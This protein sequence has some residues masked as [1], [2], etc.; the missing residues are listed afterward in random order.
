MLACAAAASDADTGPEMVPTLLFRSNSRNLKIIKKHL[1]KH[2]AAS[3]TIEGEA[4]KLP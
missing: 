3:A 2:H 1:N 4:T